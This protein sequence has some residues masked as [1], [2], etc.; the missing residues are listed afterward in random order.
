MR[1]ANNIAAFV[2]VLGTD[3]PGLVFELAS[4]PWKSDEDRD[5]FIYEVATLGQGGQQ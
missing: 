5:K 4:I 2:N 1:L 3:Y